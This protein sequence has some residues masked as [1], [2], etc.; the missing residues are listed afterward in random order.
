MLLVIRF[1]IFDQ[2]PTSILF[3]LEKQLEVNLCDCYVQAH[4]QCKKR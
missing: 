3:N 2:S 4:L 1:L